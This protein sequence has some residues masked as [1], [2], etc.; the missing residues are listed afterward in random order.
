MNSPVFYFY[1]EKAVFYAFLINMIKR[2][3]NKNKP[4]NVFIVA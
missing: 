3:V 4:Q 1:E 2:V